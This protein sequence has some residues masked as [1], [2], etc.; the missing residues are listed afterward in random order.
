MHSFIITLEMSTT[1]LKNACM[2]YPMQTKLQYKAQVS[3]D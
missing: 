2:P 1:P 3:T